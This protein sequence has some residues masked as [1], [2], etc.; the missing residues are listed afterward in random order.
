MGSAKQRIANAGFR[1]NRLTTGKPAPS[2]KEAISTQPTRVLE[3]TKSSRSSSNRTSKTAVKEQKMQP[4]LKIRPSQRSTSKT[5][6]LKL[7]TRNKSNPSKS[8][9]M[10]GKETC[11]K[12][13][14][15]HS[16]GPYPVRTSCTWLKKTNKYTT[17]CKM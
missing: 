9:N 10:A 2:L 7:K 1:A 8:T 17:Q 12:T 3:K 6:P 14:T 4:H 5:N 16:Y 15:R 11:I 13:T